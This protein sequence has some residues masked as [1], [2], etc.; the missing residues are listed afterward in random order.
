MAKKKQDPK[1]P[2]EIQNELMW[3]SNP[4]SKVKKA[5][6]R[7]VIPKEVKEAEEEPDTKEE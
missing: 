5:P 7:T 1:A 3:Y 4:C 2:S 6:S